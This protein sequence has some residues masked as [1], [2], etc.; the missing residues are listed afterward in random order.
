MPGFLAKCTDILNRTWAEVSGIVSQ[1][2]SYKAVDDNKI[3]SLVSICIN[4]PTK[5]YRYVLPTQLVAKVADSSLDSRC[6]QATRNKNHDFDARSI[7]DDVVVPFDRQNHSVLGGSPEPYVN[8]PLRVPEITAAYG[9]NQKDKQGWAALVYI[10]QAV[11]DAKDPTFTEAVFRQTLVEIYRCL[12][13]VAVVFPTPKRA[14]LEQVQRI[15]AAYLSERSGGERVLTVVSALMQ[16]V[17]ERFRLYAVVRR[18]RITSADAPSGFVSDIECVDPAG[19]IVLAVEV[20]DREL[21]LNHLATKVANIRSRKVSE[22]LYIA[23]KGIAKSDE[24]AIADFVEHE[25]ASGQNFYVFDD[26]LQ[27]GAGILAI[28]GEDGRRRFLECVGEH[29]EQ[30]KS[31]VEHK[32]S[33]V[34]LLSSI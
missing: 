31:A 14:S 23:Q 4:S 30:Y 11:E 6:V 8:N 34:N 13:S 16:T 17:G 24:K 10:L 33:W 9:G 29:L 7:C 1:D 20:K 25:F 12:Q 3:V 28:L 27:F 18:G 19:N 21:R 26:V 32:K 22:I 5:S 15:I 2:P